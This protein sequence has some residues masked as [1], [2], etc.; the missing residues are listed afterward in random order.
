MMKITGFIAS[1]CK[2]T[3]YLIGYQ[4]KWMPMVAWK[5]DIKQETINNY[6]DAH[7]SKAINQLQNKFGSTFLTTGDGY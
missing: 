1:C 7:V 6:D 2:A 5:S 3:V 4:G